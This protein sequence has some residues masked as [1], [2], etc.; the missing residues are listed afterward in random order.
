M[1]PPSGQVDHLTD[2]IIMISFIEDWI[3]GK[4]P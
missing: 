1:Y 3:F 4:K 2:G